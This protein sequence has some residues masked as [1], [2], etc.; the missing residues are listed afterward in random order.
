[1]STPDETPA[2]RV[3]SYP[4]VVT[5]QPS[6][7]LDD[8]LTIDLREPID[9]NATVERRVI[10]LRT[11]HTVDSVDTVLVPPQAGPPVPPPQ[12][13]ELLRF[14]PGVPAVIAAAPVAT[15]EPAPPPRRLR[16]H[17]ALNIALTA[18]LAVAVVWLLWPAGSLHVRSI[19]ARATPADVACEQTANVVATVRTNGNPGRLHYRW[20]RNDGVASGT[21]VQSLAKGQHSVN[22]RLTWSFHGPGTYNARATVQLLSA[23]N[24]SATVNFRY[25]C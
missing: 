6:P 7:P 10:D 13:V 3:E 20:T 16:R 24:P 1:M 4:T 11:D 21:L 5:P 23:D 25:V 19:S 8:R 12:P 18:A 22:L 9:Q 2:T 14:G 15:A 17:R